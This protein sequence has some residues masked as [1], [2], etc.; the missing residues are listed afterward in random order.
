VH[1]NSEYP[2]Q[3]SDHEPQVVRLRVG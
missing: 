3:V 1:V 2:D